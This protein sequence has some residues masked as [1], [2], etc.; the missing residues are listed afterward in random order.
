MIASARTAMELPGGDIFLD[1]LSADTSG[2][3][4]SEAASNHNL[5][6]KLADAAL[7][8]TERFRAVA[9]LPSAEGVLAACRPH[10][11]RPRNGPGM[12][13][14]FALLALTAAGLGL[15]LLLGPD[16]QPRSTGSQALDAAPVAYGVW[17][18]GLL[19]G[20]VLAWLARVEWSTL[21]ARVSDWFRIQRRRL[22]WALLG[23]VFAGILL[24]F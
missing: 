13:R 21:P 2:L 6:P 17:A 8:L 1:L 22:A 9:R 16:T 24:L 11:K 15:F 7:T 14:F 19:M 12:H 4:R 18:I 3:H 5:R 10:A 23:G 20:L